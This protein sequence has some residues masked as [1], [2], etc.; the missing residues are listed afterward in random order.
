MLTV[1]SDTV[2]PP[3][4]DERPFFHLPYYLSFT[5]G[6]LFPRLPPI[7]HYQFKAKQSKLIQC[8]NNAP[9]EVRILQ[10]EQ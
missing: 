9:Q 10:N 8:L 7:A 4:S 2:Y 6:F 3:Q 1:L 5:D